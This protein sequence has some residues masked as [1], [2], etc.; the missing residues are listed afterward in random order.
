M[1]TRSELKSKAKMSFKANYWK[2]VLIA[3]LV[4]M[5]IGGGSAAG[6]G[7]S[8]GTL[9]S[10]ASQAAVGA[11]VR[12]Y[13]SEDV[14]SVEDDDLVDT[15]D[16]DD[17]YADETSTSDEVSSSGVISTDTTDDTSEDISFATSFNRESLDGFMTPL[18]GVLVIVGLIV[19]AFLI[20]I[21]ILIIYPLEVGA[22]RF[23]TRNLNQPAEVKEVAHA[24]DH[25]YVE[26]IK[27]LFFR[28]LY[29]FLWSLLLI[30]PGIVKSYEYCMIPYLLADDPTMT[31][32]RAFA[33]S[34]AL[35]DGNKWKTFVLDISFIGWHLLSVLTLGILDTF[36][37][38]P[39]V[40]MT[41]AALYEELRYG[42][43]TPALPRFETP[44]NPTA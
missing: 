43:S 30:I 34:K 21:Q 27:T 14:S 1:W 40:C 24:F 44:V 25:N 12:T 20:A 3:L 23:F 38:S 16:T 8:S 36:Y 32:E 11:G 5:V 37:V 7:T 28:D 4:G 42:S 17:E 18:L 15:F 13:D 9:S 2:T 41:K 10:M 35:M 26:S 39:Y 22:T 31:R 29:T 19:V 33:E 6:A